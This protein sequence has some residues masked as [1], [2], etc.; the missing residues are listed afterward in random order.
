MSPPPRDSRT[1]DL[2][3]W[4]PPPLVKRFDEV[5]VRAG[6]LRQRIALAV[7]ETLKESEMSREEIANGMTE[8][9][10]EEMSKNM[11]DAYASQSREEHSISLLR[12]LALLHVTGDMRLLQ[13]AA[14]LFGH[15]VIENRYLP[16]VEVGM[17]ADHKIESDKSFD[18]AL[19]WAKK[20]AK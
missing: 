18:A 6:T 2:F 9:L 17:R 4:E 12:V 14:D 10:G 13:L 1:L 3:S 16:W 8:W 5:R 20:V 11:L 19:R 15:S 7:S